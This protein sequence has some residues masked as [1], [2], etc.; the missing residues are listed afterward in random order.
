MKNV[1]W[2]ETE[3]LPGIRQLYLLDEGVPLT[4]AQVRADWTAGGP[5]THALRKGLRGLPF[6]AFTWETPPVSESEINHVPFECVVSHMPQL[7]RNAADATAFREH[8]GATDI[9][10]FVS[11]KGDALLI[12][13]APRPGVD[14]AH[15]AAFA[16][17]A[18]SSL[19]LALLRQV[20]KADAEQRSAGHL[21]L[22]TAGMGVP[23]LH[24]RLDTRPKYYR[25]RPYRDGQRWH[26]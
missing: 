4:W 17:T 7:A 11:L 24:V 13:P 15:F 19:W 3:L 21:W 2:V 9:A 12:S 10:S 23:W 20:A 14:A 6:D 22:S 26:A 18:P 25:H 16:R 1:R 8:F 5:A